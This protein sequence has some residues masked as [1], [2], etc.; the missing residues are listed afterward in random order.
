MPFDAALARVFIFELACALVAGVMAVNRFAEQTVRIQVDRGHT[1]VTTDP[2]RFVRHPM[3]VS[4]S[5]WFLSTA[6]ILGS[7]WALVDGAA[8]T[9]LLI[10]RTA[11]EDRTLRHELA[12][13][14]EF[15]R[16]SRYR[17]VPGVR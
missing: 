13:C 3:Y 5:L 17:L 2:Y 16:H 7:M 1:V 14:E 9:S 12:G 15:T 10:W 4:L 8:I 11:M 6:L